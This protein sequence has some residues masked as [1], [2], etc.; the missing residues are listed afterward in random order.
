MPEQSFRALDK[1]VGFFDPEKYQGRWRN[2]R[3]RFARLTG[4]G[5]DPFSVHFRSDE[6]LFQSPRGEWIVG[7]IDRVSRQNLDI[8]F[9]QLTADAAAEWFI[10]NK[11]DLPDSLRAELDQR[12]E[13][14]G[15]SPPIA[16]SG[17][18]APLRE[19]TPI[20]HTVTPGDPRQPSVAN[21]LRLHSANDAR[22]KAAQRRAREKGAWDEQLE[23]PVPP[24]SVETLLKWITDELKERAAN[25]EF[26]ARLGARRD[27]TGTSSLYRQWRSRLLEF[28]AIAPE[29][30]DHYYLKASADPAQGLLD[31]KTFLQLATCRQIAPDEPQKVPAAV[32][33]LSAE[34]RALA[35]ALRYAQEG[36]PLVITQIAKE[37]GCS[38]RYLHRCQKLKAFLAANRGDKSNLPRG[39]RDHESGGLE[40]WQGDE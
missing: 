39:R 35:V 8:V 14:M 34:N 5:P 38:A 1:G 13:A 33:S 27:L 2:R 12:R 26:H 9:R 3:R 22:F 11:Y 19:N 6:V 21:A 24:E 18:Q 30:A 4:T 40:A 23:Q 29:I 36:K 32:S 17:S 16:T 7:P 25:D 15:I 10:D 37:A 28:V 31:L 20:G